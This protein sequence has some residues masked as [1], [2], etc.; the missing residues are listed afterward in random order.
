[1][2]SLLHR[3]LRCR[4]RCAAASADAWA[5]ASGA[6]SEPAL[7]LVA[8]HRAI[9]G[10]VVGVRRL[11]AL[12]IPAGRSSSRR[13]GTRVFT[14]IGAVV[15]RAA[16]DHLHGGVRHQPQHIARLQADVLHPQVARH[17]VADLAEPALKS[18]RSSPALWRSIRYSN[19]SKM[20]SATRLTSASC[21][22]H[23][24]QLLLEHQHARGDRRH[25]VVAGVAPAAAAAGCWCSLS[26]ATASRSPELE[27]R[28]AAAALAGG[29]SVTAMPLCS[30]TAA[31]SCTSSGSL[32]LP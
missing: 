11:H 1:M 2:V 12:R 30:N 18:V 27:L 26:F 22:K 7:D 32:R 10:V 3:G 4:R 9:A 15:A 21:G 6:S 20:C 25:D 19:G 29:A 14:R 23:Q 31:R 28:H 17:V 5:R 8:G 16:L 13:R 24:R